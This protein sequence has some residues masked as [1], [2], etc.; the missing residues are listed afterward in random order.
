MAP[1]VH[2]SA[3]GPVVKLWNGPVKERWLPPKTSHV[4]LTPLET[5]HSTESEYK[6]A[7]KVC[8]RDAPRSAAEIQYLKVNAQLDDNGWSFYQARSEMVETR[9]L[10]G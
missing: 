9:Y 3:V 7:D 6:V 8:K 4:T 1:V 5:L 10:L 2:F